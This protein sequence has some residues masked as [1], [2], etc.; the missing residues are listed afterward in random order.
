MAHRSNDHETLMT[1][2]DEEGNTVFEDEVVDNQDMNTAFSDDEELLINEEVSKHL[3][4]DSTFVSKYKIEKVLG[5]GAMGIAYLAEE[6]GSQHKVVIKEFFPKKIV[7]RNDNSEV[8]L[9]SN[10]TENNHKE[11][12]FKKKVFMEEAQKLSSVNRLEQHKNVVGFTFLE[13]N[14]NNTVYYAMPY[15]EGEELLT[16]LNRQKEENK[17]LSQKEIMKIIKPILKGL[18]HI[19]KYSVLHKDIKPANI[20]M[21]KNDEP[22]LI[23][24]GAS[25]TSAN[26]LTRAYAPIEQ[27]NKQLEDYGPYTDIYA[28]GVMMYEMVTGELPP[29]S[30]DRAEALLQGH[31]DPYVSLA[32]N[33]IIKGFEPHFLKAIDHALEYSYTKRPETAKVFLEELVGDLK[34]KRRNKMISWILGITI[35]S[36][37]LGWIA[38]ESLKEKTFELTLLE[39]VTEDIDI[40]ID[41]QPKES[42]SK[43]ANGYPI[44]RLDAREDHIYEV[45]K[46]GFMTRAEKYKISGKENEKIDKE[47]IFIPDSVELTVMVKDNKDDETFKANIFLNG[48]DIGREKQKKLKFSYNRE[49]GLTQKFRIEANA[50]N[51]LPS[52][53]EELTYKELMTKE[54]IILVLTKKESSIKFNGPHGFNIKID[55]KLKKDNN[56]E[57]YKIPCIIDGLSVGNHQILLYSNEGLDYSVTMGNRVVLTKVPKYDKID[58]NLNLEYAKNEKVDKKSIVSKEYIQAKEKEIVNKLAIK[59]W[60]FVQKREKKAL[61]AYINDYPKSPKVKEAKKALIELN[62][63]VKEAKKKGL[64][65]SKEILSKVKFPKLVNVKGLNVAQTEVTYDELVRYLNSAKLSIE[66]LKEYFYCNGKYIAKYISKELSDKG[67]YHYFVAKENVEYPVTYISWKGANAYAKWLSTKSANS[68]RLLT[69]AEWTRVSSVGFS[70]NSIDSYAF[71]SENSLG[72]SP[73]KNKLVTASG[74][75]DVFGNVAEWSEDKSG[76]YARIILGGSFKSN[77]SLMNPDEHFMMNENRTRNV[78]IGFRV[79]QVN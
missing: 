23:D 6:S 63:K 31:S 27:V 35:V 67:E 24:F 66:K 32:N 39:K 58:F 70:I 17:K 45:R 46:T 47:I 52:N 50:T 4:I 15:S 28:T 65:K 3:A 69:L 77:K 71:H 7:L 30:Q 59:K 72:L 13:K 14:V 2:F 9:S 33:K 64:N 10:A 5:Q 36:A 60:E 62:K 21:R 76:E 78:D 61:E 79:I 20:F 42:D 34:R 37:I 41:G 48:K 22:M 16:Y 68:Y 18:T 8:T 53:V 49:E 55:G 57:K 54:E 43:S 38:Y 29:R 44:Y 26:L 51:Y 11:Y 19:H 75:Y 1:L 74:L 56:N 73:V 12:E 25:V 40:Y